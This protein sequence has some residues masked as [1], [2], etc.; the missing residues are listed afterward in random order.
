M[1]QC[2]QGIENNSVLLDVVTRKSNK[3]HYKRYKNPDTRE[4]LLGTKC[5]TRK[6]ITGK[7]HQSCHSISYV[8]LHQRWPKFWYRTNIPKVHCLG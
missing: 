7:V 1:K 6:N 8:T 2:Q 3:L 5:I 4:V